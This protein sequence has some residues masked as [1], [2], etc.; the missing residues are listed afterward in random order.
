MG[1]GASATT[2]E[3]YLHVIDWY[4]PSEVRQLNVSRPV[5]DTTVAEKLAAVFGQS[6]AAAAERLP[7]N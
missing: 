6:P 1:H 7:A 2:A 5:S 4:V 3:H